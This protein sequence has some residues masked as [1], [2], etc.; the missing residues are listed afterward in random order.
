M[1][2]VEKL[3]RLVRYIHRV[4][5]RPGS[6]GVTV[7]LYVDASYGVHCDGKSHTRTCIVLGDVEAVHCWSSK[8]LIVTK[9]STEAELVGL[10]DSANQAIYIREFLLGQGYDMGPIVVYQDNQSCIVLV[11]RVQSELGTYTSACCNLRGVN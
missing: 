4:V 3:Q 9:S 2:E 5:V 11:E 6:L 10:S 1:D 8:Q 7:R